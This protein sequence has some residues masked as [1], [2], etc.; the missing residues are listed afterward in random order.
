MTNVGPIGCIP[1]ERD[2]NLDAGDSC[3]EKPNQLARLFNPELKS[4][5]TELNAN[6]E[7]SKFVYADVYGIVNDITQN[8][9]S[10]G[11]NE[12]AYENFNL[13]QQVFLTNQ[14]NAVLSVFGYVKCRFCECK[15]CMLSCGGALRGS[16]S[17]RSSVQSLQGEIK[18]CV[19]GSLPSF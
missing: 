17:V 9:I 11:E 14:S 6:L 19:L 18:V 4:L 1:Y 16:D 7:G 15:F 10:F 13:L 5:L 3:V 12:K 2:T 8:Y